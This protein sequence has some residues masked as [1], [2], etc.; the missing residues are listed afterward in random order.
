MDESYP[1]EYSTDQGSFYVPQ[2]P[3]DTINH[4]P[5]TAVTSSDHT[6]RKQLSSS[7]HTS[8]KQL[9]YSD[10]PF[11]NKHLSTNVDD[12]VLEFDIYPPVTAHDTVDLI[13]E[14]EVD[15][16]KYKK[17]YG[18]DNY[19]DVTSHTARLAESQEFKVGSLHR[20]SE[21]GDIKHST[22]SGADSGVHSYTPTCH[23]AVTD[24]LTSEGAPVKHG[25]CSINRSMSL[26]SYH[27]NSS[28]SQKKIRN[29]T[30]V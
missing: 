29:E 27:T 22:G 18:F 15:P 10:I 9:S 17:Y 30:Y 4:T 1:T 20:D 5:V 28:P 2:Y 3:A 24:T 7:N 11:T 19:Y 26:N 21:G 25:A 23:E 16:D 6:A 13:P 12:G 14:C 8:R